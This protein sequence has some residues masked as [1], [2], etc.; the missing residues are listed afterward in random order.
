MSAE[1]IKVVLKQLKPMDCQQGKVRIGKMN[2]G[3]YVVPNDLDGIDKVVSL[4]IGTDVSFDKNLADS[5]AQIYQYDH[6]V[7]NPPVEHD[8]FNFHKQKVVAVGDD[9]GSSLIDICEEHGVL[10][11]NNAL[12]KFD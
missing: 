12:L 2:D 4:G 8:S 11:T 6:T 7:D 1:N 10:E 9:E 3:G 5:G